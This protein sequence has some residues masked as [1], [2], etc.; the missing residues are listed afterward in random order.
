MSPELQDL[1]SRLAQVAKARHAQ[2]QTISDA[3]VLLNDA[4]QWIDGLTQEAIDGV[5]TFKNA[6]LTVNDVTATLYILK[7]QD[8]VTVA[9]DRP[10]FIKMANL[11]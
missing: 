3:D 4:P 7:S 1:I 11:S 9:N 8:S 2:S 5:P 10:A 6:G